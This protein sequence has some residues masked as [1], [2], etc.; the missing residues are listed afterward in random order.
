M[1]TLESV[2][3]LGDSINYDDFDY[4]DYVKIEA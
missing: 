4:P 1:E 3:K 2:D